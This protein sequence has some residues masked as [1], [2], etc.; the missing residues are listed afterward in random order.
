MRQAIIDVRAATA[1][2]WDETWAACSYATYSQSRAWAE[3]WGTYTRGLMKP[4]PL[5]ARFTDGRQVLLPLTRQRRRSRLTMR[6]L[7]SPAGTYGGWLTTEPLTPAHAEILTE[8]LLAERVP[9]WWRVNPFDPLA[10]V[11]MA[12]ATEPDETH[13]VRLERGLEAQMSHHGYREAVRKAQRAGLTTR[14]GAGPDDWETYYSIYL[15]TLERWGPTAGSVY[16]SALFELLRGRGAPG[17]DLWLVELEDGTVV[18]GA[19]NLCGPRHVAGWH[20]ASLSEYFPLNPT[21]L[22]VNAMIE[23][24]IERSFSWFDLH[25]SGGHEGVTRFKENCGGEPLKCPVIVA[26]ELTGGGRGVVADV[27]RTLRGFMDRSGSSS[28]GGSAR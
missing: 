26:G 19:V 24:A 3:D 17:I 13:I 16:G 12:R 27:V 8:W 5:L 14:K 10:A 25:P 28:S 23:D 21:K 4:S 20:M 11:P 7:S 9:L 22:L 18:S 2:E 6:H 1:A 15:S